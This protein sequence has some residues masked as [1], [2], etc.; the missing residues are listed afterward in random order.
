MVCPVLCAAFSQGVNGQSTDS[1]NFRPLQ[2]TFE[3]TTD[4]VA[5]VFSFMVSVFIT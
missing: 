5:A 1:F 2:V 4:I 3:L